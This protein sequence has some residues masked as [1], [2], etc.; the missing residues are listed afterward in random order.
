MEEKK[1]FLVEALARK[2]RAISEMENSN[3]FASV[4]N[5]LKSWEDIESN[6]KYAV[7]FLG[8]EKRAGRYG[9]MLKLIN[10]LLK[11]NGEGTKGGICP[12]TKSELYAKRAEVL[13]ELGYTV[14]V[15][16]DKKMKCISAPKDFALF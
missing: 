7:L 10:T 5:Q 9:S 12:M 16:Y 4:L 2:A 11:N 14:L 6:H 3:D 15:E 13:E 1:A 8:R